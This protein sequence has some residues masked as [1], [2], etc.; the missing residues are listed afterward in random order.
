MISVTK[1]DVKRIHEL[2]DMGLGRK[3]IS[4]YMGINESAI[5]A[6]LTGERKTIS[7]ELSIRDRQRLIDLAFGPP[8][9]R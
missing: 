7:N 9:G 3:S 2:S 8:R 4:D 6:V 1:D 5:K